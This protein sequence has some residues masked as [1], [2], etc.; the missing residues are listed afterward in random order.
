M[1]GWW[2]VRKHVLCEAPERP[3]CARL[4]AREVA[5]PMSKIRLV[6][7]DVDGTLLTPQKELTARA[8]GAV[9]AL[10]PAGI[11]FALTSGRPPRGL[12]M[13][14]EPLGI[15]TP[16]AAFNGGMLVRPDLSVI[17]QQLLPAS[18]VGPVIQA[19]ERHGLDVWLYRGVDWLIRTPTAPH[20]DREQRTV[21]FAPT[22]VGSFD[23]VREG[24][25]KL[26]GVSEDLAAVARCEADVRQELGAHVS[27]A[28]SQPYYLDVTH[29]AANKG[30]VVKRLS[31]LLNVPT[32]EIATLGDMPNDV[33]MFAL[34]G[35]G[36]AMGN[37]S[38]EVQRAA[39][40]VTASNTEEGFAEALEKYVL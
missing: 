11:A 34:G 37:A 27:A 28:R 9:L 12:S 15:T 17:E 6:V 26:V 1:N 29:P 13:L 35:L 36:I 25:V 24:V 32:E 23:D 19:L 7:A 18:V 14:I 40:R 31:T 4:R 33:L 2:P 5:Q 10:R 16:I 20:V 38:P 39:R 30:E 3:R 8:R 22:V 21:E